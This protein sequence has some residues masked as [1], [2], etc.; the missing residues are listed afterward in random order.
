MGLGTLLYIRYTAIPGSKLHLEVEHN[1]G[2]RK[3]W[4]GM[5]REWGLTIDLMPD[6]TLD[7][8]TIQCDD[9]GK[10][11]FDDDGASTDDG[12]IRSDDDV[13]GGEGG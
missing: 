7:D 9:V 12:D 5:C 1:L 8:P 13:Q 10:V 6:V 11:D 2:K 4:R 3:D